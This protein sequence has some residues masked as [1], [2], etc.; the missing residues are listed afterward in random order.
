MTLGHLILIS[1]LIILTLYEIWRD[2][3]IRLGKD[4]LLGIAHLVA[5]I[6]KLFKW[7]RL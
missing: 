7:I 5:L 3:L 6:I 1:I 4:L 2:N